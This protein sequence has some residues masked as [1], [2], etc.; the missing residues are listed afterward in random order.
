M[1]DYPVTLEK[2]S[3]GSILAN[4]TSSTPRAWIRSR[5]R[6]RPSAGAWMCR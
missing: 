5:R 3:N 1:F 6:S 2:D 4:S